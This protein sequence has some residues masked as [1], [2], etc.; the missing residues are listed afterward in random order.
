MMTCDRASRLPHI[1][2]REI[3]SLISDLGPLASQH[4]YNTIV[5][6]TTENGG[7]RVRALQGDFILESMEMEMRMRY[8]YLQSAGNYRMKGC[9][10]HN[11]GKT[12][13]NQEAGSRVSSTRTTSL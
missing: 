9:A 10:I 8:I 1:W 6:R 13:R 12:E 5:Q 11:G 2:A 3:K 4:K 7:K